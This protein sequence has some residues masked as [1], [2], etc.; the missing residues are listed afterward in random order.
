VRK[1]IQCSRSGLT[2]LVHNASYSPCVHPFFLRCCASFVHHRSFF[3]CYCQCCLLVAL[4]HNSRAYEGRC[5]C[6][7]ARVC[8]CVLDNWHQRWRCWAQFCFVWLPVRTL[9]QNL[10]IKPSVKTYVRLLGGL[11][12]SQCTPSNTGQVVGGLHSFVLNFILDLHFC[13]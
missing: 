5:L 9:K 12:G 6:V 1:R 11:Y 10:Q 13:T 2:G 7:G 4:A 3:W 8:P